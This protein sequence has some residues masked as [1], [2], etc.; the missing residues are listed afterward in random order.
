ME[1]LDPAVPPH[2]PTAP[3]HSF[4]QNSMPPNVQQTYDRLNALWDTHHIHAAEPS[5]P[6]PRPR[7]VDHGQPTHITTP[8][9]AQGP[10]SGQLQVIGVWDRTPIKM[11][12]DLD[13]SGEV[14]YQ[15]FHRWAVRRKREGDLERHRMTLWLKASKNTPDTEAYLLSLKE[16]ELEEDWETAVDWI[17]DNKSPK[18]PHLYATVELEAG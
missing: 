2:A 13:A 17:Q 9:S 12:F 4:Q 1:E 14:F 7:H 10:S 11:A 16:G 3:M 6:A 15:A 18:A 8:L 5:V